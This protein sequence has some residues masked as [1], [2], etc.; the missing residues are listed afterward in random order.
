MALNQNQFKQTPIQGE[1]DQQVPGTVIS[2][3]VDSSQATAL[4]AG[5]PVKLV[6]NAGGVPKVVSLA[7]DTDASFG[8]VVYNLKDAEYAAYARCEIAIKGSIMTMTAGAAIARGAKVE[9]VQASKKVITSAGINP[10]IG[11][12]FDKAAADGDL[13][14]VF[15]ETPAVVQPMTLDQLNDVTLTS[16][17][18]TQVLK[19]NG[20]IWVN[21]A[22]AT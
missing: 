18:N 4:V 13:I 9:A 11:W 6:D 1:M 5:Q 16:P 8:F 21:A 14:R 3:Q 15:I 20:T 22:D 2:C 7:A 19:Y 10:V 17:S 12:A